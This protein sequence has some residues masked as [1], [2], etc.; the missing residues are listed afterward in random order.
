MKRLSLILCGLLLAS[1]S[2]TGN[3]ATEGGTLIAEGASSQQSAMDYFGV[4]YNSAYSG[5]SLSYTPSG[6]GSG[7]K[8]F[9]AGQVDF[10]GSDSPLKD[11]QR[12]AAEKRC[13]SDVWHLPFVIGPVA[14]AVNLDE[15]D[16]ITLST[17]TVAKI[18]AGQIDKWNDPAVA[19]DNPNLKL[20]DT[21]IS[22]IYR[23]DESGTTDNFQ[24][25]LTAATS[26][27][28][29]GKNFAYPEAGSGAS[30]SAGV[31]TEA[32]T[33]N[34]AIT[35]VEAGFAK[36]LT[37]ADIDFGAG[38][39]SL[40][41]HTVAKALDGL[42]FTTEGNDMVVDSKK[43]FSQTT[44]GSYPLILTTYEIVCSQYPAK[45]EQ[46]RN[47]LTTALSAQDDELAALGYIPIDGN[48]DHGKRLSN[49]VAEIK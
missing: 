12:A 20:P 7:Q 16:S 5:S 28:G 44:T 10:A 14:I 45:G 11:D 38:P 30:G 13:G 41:N 33:I 27:E 24:K 15:V 39:T 1:C 29:E 19:K 37:I 47:F 31:A 6:S 46:V 4:A 36:D 26:W 8:Q 2:E 40:N 3:T 18:F 23:S 22:V 9:I 17:E 48:S 42:E 49:A 21:T 43:L 25:F 32:T 35:Y 34:G